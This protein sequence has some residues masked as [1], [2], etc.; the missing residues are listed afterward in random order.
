MVTPAK[1]IISAILNEDAVLLSQTANSMLSE[2]AL[3]KLESKKMKI[4]SEMF[5]TGE[6]S[7]RNIKEHI[8]REKNSLRDMVLESLTGNLL[9]DFSLKPKDRAELR[10]RE[11]P[12]SIAYPD[13]KHMTP[14]KKH[15]TGMTRRGLNV[16]MGKKIKRFY[17]P[18]IKT[19]YFSTKYHTEDHSLQPKDS[20]ERIVRYGVR[21][22]RGGLPGLHQRTLLRNLTIGTVVMGKDGFLRRT[23]DNKVIGGPAAYRAKGRLASSYPGFGA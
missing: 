3:T 8:S 7:T 14:D 15:Y 23:K 17:E 2:N 19:T 4:V 11:V 13:G 10:R 9:E 18:P 6:F 22:G 20:T 12:L 5:D 16:R 21:R 1:K